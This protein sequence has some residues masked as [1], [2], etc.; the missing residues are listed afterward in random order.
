MLM[1]IGIV[2][3]FILG[4]ILHETYRWSGR[5]LLV[6]FLA[7]TNESLFEH[8]KMLLTPY[9]IWMLVEYVYYGQFMHAFVPAKVLGLWLGMCLI[10]GLYLAYE[11]AAG[12]A[13]RVSPEAPA[14]WPKVLIYA[15]AVVSAFVVAEFLMTLT[16]MDSAALEIIFDVV[17]VST[18]LVFAAFTIYAPKHW[19]FQG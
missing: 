2:F 18:I 10:I 13:G 3:T 4:L 17:L 12:G 8:L 1:Y 7:P 14:V 11:W 19:L 15:V 5:N 9:L 6:A 16:F